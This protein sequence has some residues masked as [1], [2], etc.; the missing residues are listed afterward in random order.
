MKENFLRPPHAAAEWAADAV[1][2][3]GVLGVVA[4]IW[5][6]P[7]D[8]GIA[9]LALPAL[10]L[11]RVLGVRGWFDVAVCV[12][13]LTAS[14]SNV[15]DLYTRIP[16]WDLLVHFACTGILAILAALVITRTGVANITGGVDVRARTPLVLVPLI[17]LALSAI[18]EMVEWVGWAY[19][20]DEIFVAYQDTI[21]DMVFG[22]LGGIVAGIVLSR[23]SVERG[24]ESASR[25]A[26]SDAGNGRAGGT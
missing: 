10:M 7:T 19:V 20:S 14:W 9:A 21:G 17:A 8:A 6:A 23:T 25:V 1:R 22:G 15:F 24:D 11:P 3:I 12:T 26:A 16:G 13:V 5:L 4:A 2:V 18:W